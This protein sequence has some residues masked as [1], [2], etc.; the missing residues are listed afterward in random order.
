[1]EKNTGINYATVGKL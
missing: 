1:M